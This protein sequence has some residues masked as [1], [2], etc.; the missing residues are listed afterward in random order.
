MFT[1]PLP[2]DHDHVGV[3]E[4][5]VDHRGVRRLAGRDVG[6]HASTTSRRAAGASLICSV[7]SV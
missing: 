1:R 4:Q 5:R 3:G 7:P 2:L 6:T